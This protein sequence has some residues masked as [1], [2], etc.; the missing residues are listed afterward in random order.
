MNVSLKRR[1]FLAKRCRIGVKAPAM[2]LSLTIK[3]WSTNLKGPSESIVQAD[4]LKERIGRKKD[5][6][7]IVAIA[8]AKSNIYEDKGAKPRNYDDKKRI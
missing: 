7:G 5:P 2:V 8:R 4:G 1:I 6:G 3:Y